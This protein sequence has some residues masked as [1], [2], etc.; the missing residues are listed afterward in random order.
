MRTDLQG[1]GS[2]TWTESGLQLLREIN[3]LTCLHGGDNAFANFVI[4]ENPDVF[5]NYRTQT[6]A[7]YSLRN[8]RPE[9]KIKRL[10]T[11]EEIDLAKKTMGIVNK[12]ELGKIFKGRTHYAISNMRSNIR[13]GRVA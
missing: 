1:E 6:T 5:R 4:M 7:K 3:K 10:W 12:Y 13:M 9:D 11:R 8:K 2:Y